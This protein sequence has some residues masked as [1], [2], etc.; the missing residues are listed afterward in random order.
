MKLTA[1]L[2]SIV[3]QSSKRSRVRAG[4]RDELERERRLVQRFLAL[5]TAAQGKQIKPDGRLPHL[6]S[7]LLNSQLTIAEA[8]SRELCYSPGQLILLLVFVRS[9]QGRDVSIRSLSTFRILGP[10]TVAL[11]WAAKLVG[12]GI[13]EVTEAHEVDDRL[14]RL[15]SDGACR[16]EHWLRCIESGLMTDSH[17]GFSV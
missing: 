5:P 13:L 3:N 6:A 7:V 10:A 2:F 16:L 12:D 15:S 1:L 11:R 17:E 4:V 14:L 8:F 9:G